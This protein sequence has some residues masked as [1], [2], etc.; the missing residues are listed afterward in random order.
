M[1]RQAAELSAQPEDQLRLGQL[2]GLWGRS[3][4]RADRCCLDGCGD[5]QHFIRQFALRIM[6]HTATIWFF[7]DG[8]LLYEVSALPDHEDYATTQRYARTWRRTRTPR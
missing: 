5:P 1:A 6:R 7:Q 4:L 3:A 8:V 2:P